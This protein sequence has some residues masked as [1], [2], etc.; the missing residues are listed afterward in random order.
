MNVTPLPLPWLELAIV[1]A[2]LGA[3]FV[4]R[5]R[6]PILAFRWGLA[7]S[8]AA[9]ACALLSCLGFY[10][11]KFSGVDAGWSFQNYLGTRPLL[12]IDEVNAPLIPVVALLHFLTALATGGTKMRRFSI[13]WS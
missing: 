4:S 5:L 3:L 2:L 7:F 11:C 9:L 12:G 10:L 13:T 8:T 6:A 1:V